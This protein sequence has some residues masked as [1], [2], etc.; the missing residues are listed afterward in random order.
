M[1]IHRKIMIEHIIDDLQF[2]SDDFD[3]EQIKTKCQDKAFF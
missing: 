2:Y 1:Q 3:E